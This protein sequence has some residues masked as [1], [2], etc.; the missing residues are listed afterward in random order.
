MSTRNFTYRNSPRGAQ[1]GGRFVLAGPANLVLTPGVPVVANGV[2]DSLGRSEVI[3]ATGEQAKPKPGLGGVMDF[4]NIH[5]LGFDMQ[6]T[7]WSDIDQVVP[8]D[9]VQVVQGGNQTVKVA[10]TNTN[11]SGASYYGRLNYPK[12][13]IMVAGLSIA[14]PSV[15]I[16]DYL[17]PGD[18][19]DSAG[20]WKETSTA[21]NGWLVVT[22]INSSLGLVE[23]ELNW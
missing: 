23:A 13:R 6:I 8:G 19:N 20:Y 2:V 1:R 5:T 16:G 17:T 10:F 21:A 18:G 15:A 4:E 14:T 12:S 11:V 3:L 9:S 22:G 7:T